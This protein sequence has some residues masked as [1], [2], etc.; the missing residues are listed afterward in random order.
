MRRKIRIFFTVYM[1]V[2]LVMFRIQTVIKK[3]CVEKN[4]KIA[5]KI[6]CFLVWRYRF[7]HRIVGGNKQTGVQ[8]H[9]NNNH[10][11]NQG[12]AP[13]KIPCKQEIKRNKP[14]DNYG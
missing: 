14:T 1:T 9:L 10:Q 6:I 2:V 5:N 12:I 3:T 7:V 13:G 8:M 11:I 4:G